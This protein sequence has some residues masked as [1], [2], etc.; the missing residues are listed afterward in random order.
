MLLLN[1]NRVDNEKK[2]PKKR[3]EVLKIEEQREIC[4]RYECI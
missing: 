2:T 4:T 1:Q 3:G